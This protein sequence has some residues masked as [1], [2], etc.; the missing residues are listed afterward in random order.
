MACVDICNHNAL[1]ATIN[2][3]GFY[4]IY[5]DQSRC[6]DCGLCSGICPV[7][8]PVNI[9]RDCIEHSKPYASWC[10]D[11]NLRTQ[12]ASGGAFAA[13]A[14]LFLQNG[15]VVYGAAIDGFDVRHKRIE[16]IEDLPQLLGSKYQHSSME[17]IHKQIKKDLREGRVVLYSGLSCQVS[18]VISYVGKKLTPNLY[19]IDTICGGLSTLLPIL[20]LKDTGEYKGIVSYRDKDNGWKSRGYKYSL[21]LIS[22]DGDVRDLGMENMMMKCFCHKETKRLSCLDCRFN[23]FHRAAD[24]T[25]GDFWGDTRFIEQHHNGLSVVIIHSERIQDMINKAPLHI[26]PIN[27]QELVEYNHNVYWS[28]HPYLYKSITRKIVFGLLRKNKETAASWFLEK[29]LIRRIETR[30]QQKYNNQKRE[31]YLKR[32]LSQNII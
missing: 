14:K 17:G 12:S 27:W 24:I 8:K 18:G 28:H 11:D 3:D 25:I 9:D 31:D 16:T 6:V 23:G 15:G 10:T 7:L 26:E 1:T 29:S 19:T 13:I 22:K 20:R 21:K 4:Q 30:F 32:V 2:D 5:V